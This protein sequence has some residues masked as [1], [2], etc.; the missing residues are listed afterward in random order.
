M[1][2]TIDFKTDKDGMN[3]SSMKVKQERRYDNDEEL[4]LI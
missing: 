2:E 4:N 1:A 3:V